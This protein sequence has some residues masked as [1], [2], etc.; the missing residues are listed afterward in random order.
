MNYRT[1]D[2]TYVPPSPREGELAKL[3]NDLVAL[4]KLEPGKKLIVEFPNRNAS[5]RAQCRMAV[6]AEE[7]GHEL[8]GSAIPG[9]NE[10]EFYIEKKPASEQ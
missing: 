10:R 5:Y 6:W 4:M 8:F 2:K 1:V 9:S 3:Y 7:D